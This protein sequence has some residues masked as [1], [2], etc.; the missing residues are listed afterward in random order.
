MLFGLQSRERVVRPL[1][2]TE[3]GV[4]S[5]RW[6]ETAPAGTVDRRA[7]VIWLRD[8]GRVAWWIAQGERTLVLGF[9]DSLTEPDDAAIEQ[10]QRSAA[11]RWW[12][13]AS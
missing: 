2:W 10:A 9:V 6:W 13:I 12:E 5:M 8:L 11:Q 1:R 3:R 7:V 4:G